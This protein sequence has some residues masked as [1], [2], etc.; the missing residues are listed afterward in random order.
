MLCPAVDIAVGVFAVIPMIVYSIGKSI[1]GKLKPKS[2]P[3]PAAPAR[4]LNRNV[5]FSLESFSSM[6]YT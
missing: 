5:G 3:P 2:V 1:H 6:I 4:V